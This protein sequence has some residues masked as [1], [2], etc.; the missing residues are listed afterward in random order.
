MND[1]FETIPSFLQV[2]LYLTLKCKPYLRTLMNK[3][4]CFSL[5]KPSAN[6]S[7]PPS[8]AVPNIITFCVTKCLIHLALHSRDT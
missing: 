6:S 8:F 3:Y 5:S 4:L 7:I 1:L 2:L